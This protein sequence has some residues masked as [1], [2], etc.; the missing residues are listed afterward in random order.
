MLFLYR[1]TQK[2]IQHAKTFGGGLLVGG[3]GLP[4]NASDLQLTAGGLRAKPLKGPAMD[5]LAKMNDANDPKFEEAMRGLEETSLVDEGDRLTEVQKRLRQMAAGKS[6]EARAAALKLLGRL[7]DLDNVP[8]LIESLHDDDPQIF[9]AAIDALRFM[10]RK[11]SPAGQFA[12][13]NI[14]PRKESIKYWKAWYRDIR[15][16]ARFE[17]D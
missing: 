16:D 7:R 13:E 5:L 9:L 17:D 15:P 14:D 3:R 2:I 6:P 1:S 12:G 4:E 11:F 10:S 8:L